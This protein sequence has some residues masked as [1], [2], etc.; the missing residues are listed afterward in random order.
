MV[1]CIGLILEKGKNHERKGAAERRHWG[2]I[3]PALLLEGVEE[4]GVK[5]ILGKKIAEK[6]LDFLRIIECPGLKRT[7]MVVEFQTPAM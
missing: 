1:V 5:M 4:S 6:P 3:I 7:T 2:L